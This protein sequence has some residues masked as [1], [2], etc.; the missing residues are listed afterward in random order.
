[1]TFEQLLTRLVWIQYHK[2]LEKYCNTANLTRHLQLV[3]ECVQSCGWWCQASEWACN[4]VLFS[5]PAARQTGISVRFKHWV[6]VPLQEAL[7]RGVFC[8]LQLSRLVTRSAVS[9]YKCILKAVRVKMIVVWVGCACTLFLQF[10]YL[11]AWIS[12]YP[13]FFLN[14]LVTRAPT[15]F[16]PDWRS[17]NGMLHDLWNPTVDFMVTVVDVVE[18][19]RDTEWTFP[20][21]KC[22][23]GSEIYLADRRQQ[24]YVC[25][26]LL[27]Y[28]ILFQ[29]SSLPPT[30]PFTTQVYTVGCCQ[31][32]YGMLPSLVFMFCSTHNPSGLSWEVSIWISISAVKRMLD[33]E[34]LGS[35]MSCQP[36]LL[37]GNV[38][39]NYS[40]C[41][42]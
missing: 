27:K 10:I 2:E 21:Q 19:L 28:F 12:K 37:L 38:E 24:R 25:V 16:L 13:K 31:L 33:D 41:P 18:F 1:M 23:P 6:L 7:L 29:H 20:V 35:T 8:P 22:V 15:V 3:H 26:C 17:A 5:P 32:W 14:V 34:I 30:S 11:P 36:I 9:H 40:L 39:K 4:G 42:L